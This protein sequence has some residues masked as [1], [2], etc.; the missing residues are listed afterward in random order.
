MKKIYSALTVF[1]GFSVFFALPAEA[2]DIRLANKVSGFYKISQTRDPANGVV[3]E[4]RA[5]DEDT[6]VAIMINP[7]QTPSFTSIDQV[8]TYLKD[9]SFDQTFSKPKNICFVIDSSLSMNDPI[10]AGSGR[11]RRID[12]VKKIGEMLFQ[13]MKETD[14][15]SIIVFNDQKSERIV[16][17]PARITGPDQRKK[18]IDAVRGLQPK[19]QTYILRAL[20]MGYELV[21]EHYD[22]GY[23][24]RV[25]L[26]TDGDP[27]DKREIGQIKELVLQK[28][29][30][31]IATVSTIALSAEAN[32]EFMDELATIGGG[33]SLYVNESDSE[34]VIAGKMKTLIYSN[35]R[36][37]IAKLR[38]L[39]RQTIWELDVDI[40]LL[41]GVGWKDETACNGVFPQR[42]GRTLAYRDI[43]LSQSKA[44]LVQI[45][46]IL[47][48]GTISPDD[49]FTLTISN[50]IPANPAF[51][52]FKFTKTVSLN[53]TVETESDDWCIFIRQDFG[54][55]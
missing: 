13:D 11:E 37:I 44:A 14:F 52:A 30:A 41:G 55:D 31:G 23:I 12:W 16:V 36:E 19:G 49:I 46:I 29:Q 51:P 3:R 32:R 8:W 50:A 5:G 53:E 47:D 2:Q 42:R 45:R 24:N 20:E 18:C 25:I 17:Q 38:A 10:N 1:L 39:F 9:L 27:S 21:Q 40:T 26:L 6:D 15:I 54:K 4:I 43:P 34:Q 35:R 7:P 48:P 28:N 33:L 22:A